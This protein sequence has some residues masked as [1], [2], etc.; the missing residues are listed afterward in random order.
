MVI[1]LGP[2]PYTTNQKINTHVRSG[3]LVKVKGKT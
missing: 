2:D 3:V 1:Q